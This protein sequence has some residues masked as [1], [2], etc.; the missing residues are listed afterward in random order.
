VASER[1]LATRR[2]Y[3]GHVLALRVD[4]VELPSGRRV[5]REIV[6]HRGAV[7]IVPMVGGDV[8]LVRRFRAAVGRALLEV[9]AGTM[10]P[11][12]SVEACL[13]RELAEEVGMRAGRFERL[14]TF[15]P[16]PGFLTEA[17]HLYAASDLTPHRLPAEEED[18]AVV[19]VP[20]AQAQGLLRDGQIVDAKSIIGLLLVAPGHEAP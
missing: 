12:E 20:L 1:P 16:S 7:A 3:E 17:V 6:E 9:P 15:Y 13:Q 4:E 5:V 14:L 19:R 18:L 11:G 10:E 8:L 2:V